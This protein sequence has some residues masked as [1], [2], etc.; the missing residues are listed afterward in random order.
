MDQKSECISC[1]RQIEEGTGICC[2]CSEEY[3]AYTLGA[4]QDL[5]SMILN[6]EIE[7]PDYA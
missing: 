2:E 1:G 6:M 4:E 5:R 3:E 7:T